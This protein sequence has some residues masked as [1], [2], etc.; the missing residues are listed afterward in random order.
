MT[1]RL[2]FENAIADGAFTEIAQKPLIPKAGS[3]ISL[4]RM[5]VLLPS[6]NGYTRLGERDRH[7]ERLAEMPLGELLYHAL[8]GRGTIAD[9]SA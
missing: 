5:R 3:N 1:M 9:E 6:V 4:N 2:K 7:S 8:V